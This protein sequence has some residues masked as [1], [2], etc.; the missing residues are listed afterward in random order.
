[1]HTTCFFAICLMK[2]NDVLLGPKDPPEDPSPEIVAEFPLEGQAT[3]LGWDGLSQRIVVAV[4][5]PTCDRLCF[6]DAGLGGGGVAFLAG[7]LGL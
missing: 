3:S 7:W 6:C 2:K 5:G 1:M 4:N